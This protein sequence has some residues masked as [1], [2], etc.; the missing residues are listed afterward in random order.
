[1]VKSLSLWR[2]RLQYWGVLLKENMS[3]K[4][5]TVIGSLEAHLH[6][7]KFSNAWKHLNPIKTN[8][9]NKEV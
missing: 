6:S 8:N 3:L 1:M 7:H 5:N 4:V 2:L 9:V